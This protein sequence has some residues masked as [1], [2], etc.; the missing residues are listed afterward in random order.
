M[1]SQKSAHCGATFCGKGN[2]LSAVFWSNSDYFS[3]FADLGKGE[4]PAVD[5]T[6]SPS[7]LGKKT[8]L[9]QKK[10]AEMC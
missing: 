4:D 6:V 9:F 7:V 10:F 3:A 2:I 8:I 5:F 1:R